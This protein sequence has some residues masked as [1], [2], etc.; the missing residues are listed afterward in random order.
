MRTSLLIV[1]AV[2]ASALAAGAAWACSCIRYN[3][4]AEQLA[5]ADVMFVGRAIATTESSPQ[6]ATTRF[7]V[8]R[9]LKG[10]HRAELEIRHVINDGGAEC[11]VE[12]E[13]GQ[14]T[15]VIAYFAR[16]GQLE[17]NLCG[18]PQFPLADYEAIQ[19]ELG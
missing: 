19:G 2:A 3:D 15:P 5:D 17:T 1:A 7:H 9:T 10:E 16:D 14:T 12:F 6:L 18:E 13:V 11:G 8:L 4:A